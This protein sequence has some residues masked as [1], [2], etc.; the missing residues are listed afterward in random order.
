LGRDISN[1]RR[2]S[3]AISKLG[4]DTIAESIVVNYIWN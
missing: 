4:G 1:P 2:R 3:N